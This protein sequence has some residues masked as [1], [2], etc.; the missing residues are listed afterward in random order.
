MQSYLLSCKRSEYAP[1]QSAVCVVVCFSLGLV[2]ISVYKCLFY[3]CNTVCKYFC[4]W[5]VHVSAEPYRVR[6]R[7]LWALGARWS[8]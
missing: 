5:R 6:E 7:V 2:F 8:L 1:C 3:F 4:V